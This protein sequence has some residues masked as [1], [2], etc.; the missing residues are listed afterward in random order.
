MPMFA[1]QCDWLTIASYN[2]KAYTDLAAW[3]RT[4]YTGK[5]KSGRWLQYD[6]FNGP[7][8]FYG[9]A[10]QSHGKEHYIMKV[11]GLMSGDVLAKILPQV[12][13]ENWY[14]TRIDL[15]AT[16]KQPDWWLPRDTAD[17]IGDYARKKPTLIESETGSTVYVG[18]RSSGRFVRLYE[19]ELMNIA[20]LR[21][22]IELK[23][24]HAR[25][26]W[27]YLLE[28]STVR[29]LFAAHL[30]KL[31]I[32]DYI[33]DTYMPGEREELDLKIAQKESDDAKTMKWFKS[34]IPK[35]E[36]MAND[37]AIGFQFRSILMSILVNSGDNDYDNPN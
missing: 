12:W 20:H 3:L 14:A 22:E 18:S 29:S 26:A 9:K 37:H 1:P 27:H 28:G 16:I 23:A 24:D 6:G 30:D 15:E 36:K 21:C 35:F 33:K 11:S 25:L 19:K 34:L 31:P 7:S 10:L 32:P 2:F 4:T 5:W 17:A 8:V 13:I